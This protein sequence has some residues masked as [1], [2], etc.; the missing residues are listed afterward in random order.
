MLNLKSLKRCS[1]MIGC[2]DA[3]MQ[4]DQSQA[5]KEAILKGLQDLG[6][7]GANMSEAFGVWKG[8]T[9][10]AIRLEIINNWL[11]DDEFNDLI[12]QLYSYLLKELNQEEIAVTVDSVISN[13]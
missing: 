13:L 12:G 2:N 8:S 6:I 9:E 10:K 5:T 1:M 7:D 4:N 11:A 3:S